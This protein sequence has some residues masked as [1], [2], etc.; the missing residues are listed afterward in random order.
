[1]L[2]ILVPIT[3]TP[4]RIRIR[5]AKYRKGSKPW[6]SAQIGSYSIYF[7]LSSATV[8]DADPDQDPA[9]HFDADPDPTF[10]FDAERDPEI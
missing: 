6:K 2:W 1:L 5:T 10:H 9:Y 3:L 8:I 7:G 4:I